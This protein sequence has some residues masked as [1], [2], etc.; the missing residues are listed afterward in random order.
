M[1]RELIE[2]QTHPIFEG[3]TW[4]ALLEKPFVRLNVAAPYLPFAEGNFP[5]PSGRC[6][7][8]SEQMKKDGYDPLPN[9][10]E[11]NW[12]KAVPSTK[13]GAGGGQSS[14]PSPGEGAVQA[15]FGSSSGSQRFKRGFLVCI[16]PPAHSFLNSTFVN[17]ERF[18]KRER[19]PL[20][21][22]NPEDAAER[23]ITDGEKVA[24][25]NQHGEVALTAS[26]TQNIVQGTV[27]APGVWWNKLSGSGRNIN[28]VTN[29]SETDMG[30]GATFYDVLVEVESRQTSG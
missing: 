12:R 5:T 17:V 28:Q 22:I 20:L 8:Y 19:E 26:V 2:S 6:E 27:L 21:W 9:F 15:S 14:H 23:N 1:L 25:Y 24:V 4:E 29:Q 10:S 18:Q 16:S 13:T 11:P 3:V 30:G 7:F